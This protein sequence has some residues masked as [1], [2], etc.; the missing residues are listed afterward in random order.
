MK[1]LLFGGTSDG[2]ILA[3][4]LADLPLE[5]TISVA[6]DYGRDMLRSLPGST[7]VLTGRL[8]APTMECLLRDQQYDIVIDAT[9][10]YA[11]EASRTIRD[12]AESV[13][14]PL[15]RLRR[16]PG[17][18]GD[19]FCLPSAA[20]A[21]RRLAQTEGNVLLAT[22]SK[23]LAAFA[24]VP[25]FTRRLYPR[26]LPTVEA[27]GECLR[28]GFARSNVIAMQGPFSRELNAAL[29]RQFAIAILV[30]K[31]GGAAGGF[32]EK[33]EAARDLGVRVLLI[34]RPEDGDGMD[35]AQIMDAVRSRLETKICE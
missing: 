30:T 20:E 7:T 6:T 26:V 21:A 1:V 32:R 34:E 19:F 16:E 12:A 4:R 14:A 23:D 11:T 2:R 8:D 35:A 5:L 13:G 3:E 22:G 17:G 31:D 10:P 18:E 9:H 27:L 33:V 15:L 24:V 25:D 29:M 28:L